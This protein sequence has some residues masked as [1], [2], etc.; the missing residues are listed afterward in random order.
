MDH[1]LQPSSPAVE[2]EPVPTEHVPASG[3]SGAARPTAAKRGNARLLNLALGGALVLA[4]GGVA[5]AAGRMTAP[6][7]AGTGLPRGQNFGNGALPGSSGAPGGPGGFGGFGGAGG[8]GA[9]V[10]GTVESI[11]GTTLTLKTA[12]GQTIQIALS[13][14]TTYHA[15]TDATS[16]AVAAGGKVLV[17][18]GFRGTPGTGNGNGTGNLSASDVTVVP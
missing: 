9:S 6:A 12:D 10:E 11:S 1:D 4:I 17:R 14:T 7:T 8:G 15:Q 18:I 16:D 5:F 3:V 2:P 13:D